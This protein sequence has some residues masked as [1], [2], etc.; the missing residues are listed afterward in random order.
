[1][2]RIVVLGSTGM[3]GHEIVRLF[4]KNNYNVVEINSQGFS[5]FNSKVHKFDVLVDDVQQL[6]PILNE[7]DLVINCI[8]LIRHRITELSINHQINAIKINSVF[9]KQLSLLSREK[10]FRVIH[11]ATDCIFSGE[12]G[13]YSELDA[14]DASDLYG[15]SKFIGETSD[16][17]NL[18]LRCSIIGREL[19]RHIE[20]LDWVLAGVNKGSI[21]GYINHNW[22]GITSLHFAKLVKGIFDSN[23]KTSGTFHI[24]PKGSSTKFS[25]ATLITEIFEADHKR[26]NQVMAPISIDRTLKTEYPEFNDRIWNLA[27]YPVIPDIKEMLME[28]KESFRE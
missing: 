12:R 25:L 9:P 3:V 15:R 17:N 7:H 18:I 8:G 22:N 10:N 4:V 13:N 27:G 20:F 11:P 5:K 1:M 28:Y 2:E 6:N 19:T 26:I 23:D 16:S 14:S 24:V 21:N